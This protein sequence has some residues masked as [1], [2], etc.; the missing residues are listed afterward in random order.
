[1]LMSTA[2]DINE[3][4]GCVSLL[5]CVYEALEAKVWYAV[6]ILF[7]V[8]KRKSKDDRKRTTC[9]HIFIVETLETRHH[10]FRLNC[11]RLS[12][13][14]DSLHDALDIGPPFS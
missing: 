13:D 12:K 7:Y 6:G 4:G 3:R 2:E 14:I 5:F 10:C 1:M 9:N 11:R 8:E